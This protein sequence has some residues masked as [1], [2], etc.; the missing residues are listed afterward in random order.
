MLYC[1]RA[2]ATVNTVNIVTGMLS[3]LENLNVNFELNCSHTV[4][5]KSSTLF[6]CSPQLLLLLFTLWLLLLTLTLMHEGDVERRLGGWPAS[7]I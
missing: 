1:Y 5:Q 7:V 4:H 3:A 2:L 6:N